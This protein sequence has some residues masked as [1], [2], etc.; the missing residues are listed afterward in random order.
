MNRKALTGM[1]AVAALAV[2][3]CGCGS[4][5]HP[6]TFGPMP[7][8]PNALTV[9]LGPV[10]GTGSKTLTVTAS[11]SMSLTIGCFG[12]GVLTVSGPLS[13]GAVLCYDADRSRGTFAGYYW[14]H[15]QARQGE[16]IKLRVAADA[17]TTWDIRIDGLPRQ[18]QD[19]VCR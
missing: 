7:A 9:V 6:P 4:Q 12:K 8:D 1:A 10:T 11:R 13:A 3:C 17:R 15:V 18:C 16:R 2:A 19:D 14:S 5:T